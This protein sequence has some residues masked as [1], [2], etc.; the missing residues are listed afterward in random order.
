MGHQEKKGI[1]EVPVLRI[2][3]RRRRKDV[4]PTAFDRAILLLP[5]LS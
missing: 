2:Q 5:L 4:I 3:K 1:A